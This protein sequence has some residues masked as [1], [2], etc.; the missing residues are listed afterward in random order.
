MAATK[1]DGRVTVIATYPDHASAEDAVRR[2]QKEGV[3]MQNVSII[4]KDFQTVEQPLR[5]V[6]TGTVA[7]GGRQGRGVDGRPLRP[8]GRGRVPDPAGAGGRVASLSPEKTAVRD[9]PPR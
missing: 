7:K 8:A 6:S 5:F 9:G 4:G 3:P 1:T 2:L